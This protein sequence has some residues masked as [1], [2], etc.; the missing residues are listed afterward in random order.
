MFLGVNFVGI[1][2]SDM[3]R[4]L[5]F[6]G[7]KF[8][9]TERLFEYTG[10]LPGMEKVTGTPDTQARVVMLHNPNEGPIGRGLLKLVQLLSSKPE[11]CTVVDGTVWGDIGIAECCFNCSVSAGQTFS[12]LWQKGIEPELTPASGTC[13][14][15]GLTCTF[16][17]L[18][19]PDNTLL[20]LIDYGMCRTKGTEPDSGIVIDPAVEGVNHVGFGVSDLEA[21][22][23][24]YQGLGLTE[25]IFDIPYDSPVYTMATMMP[26]P[27]PKMR[28]MMFGNYHG[29]WIEPIQLATT[30]QPRPARE[31]WGH[32]GAM[33]FGIGV[34][35]IDK[36]YK[37]LQ[38]KG[39]SFLSAPQTVKLE[40]GE[41]KYAYI[42]EPD[43][44]H[45]SLIEQR[46]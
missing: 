25:L 6:Y 41:W 31:S 26:S 37:E 20:E 14:P 15:Y 2:V 46:Y 21:T 44:I 30:P 29:A 12:Q 11:P 4:A 23:K 22:A 17:Y 42:V 8:G 32:L 45:V 33:E 36:A 18:R 28:I 13:P 40:S 10:S 39:Y 27:A 3:D 19:D 35:N 1:G 38:A 43:G 34:T 7:D 5:S 24:F 9:F 16:A